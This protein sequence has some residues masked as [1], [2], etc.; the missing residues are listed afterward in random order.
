MRFNKSG[1]GFS[2]FNE[3]LYR[4]GSRGGRDVHEVLRQCRSFLS[5]SDLGIFE[6]FNLMIFKLKRFFHR[7]K[8]S[9][10]EV[11]MERIIIAK[12]TSDLKAGIDDAMEKDARRIAIQDR[13]A[14]R[15][16]RAVKAFNSIT[17][18]QMALLA[19]AM[20]RADFVKIVKMLMDWNVD[21][22]R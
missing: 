4:G 13:R 15:A 1:L 14:K 20:A 17:P 2:G 6:L 16:H 9:K 12:T 10:Q 18:K 8:S 22:G 5:G 19:A 7:L 11:V 21:R 3:Q